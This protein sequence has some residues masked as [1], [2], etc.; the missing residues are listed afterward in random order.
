MID[1]TSPYR[2]MEL[3][4]LRVLADKLPTILAYCDRSGHCRF[5]NRAHEQW[6]GIAPETLIGKHAREIL[7]PFYARTKPHIDA[8]LAGEEREFELEMP[9]PMGGPPRYAQVQYI[10]HVV[11]GTVQGLCI[12]GVDVSRRKRAEEGL[13]ELGRQLRATERLAAM[14]TLAAGLG[15]EI[16][17]PLASVLANI[18]LA[19]EGLQGRSDAVPPVEKELLEARS[20]VQRIGSIVQNMRL[21]A[22]GDLEKWELVDVNTVVEQSVAVAAHALRYRARLLRDLGEVGQIEGNASQLAQVCVNLLLNAAQALPEETPDRNE[23]RLTTR[24]E[25]DT[26]LI[27]VADNGC[28]IPE[29]ILARI[30]EPFFT[31]KDVVGGMGLGL[32][33][34]NRTVTAL[35]GKLSV[36]SQ[37]GSGSS[38]R[39]V[40]PAARGSLVQASGVPKP[41]PPGA[42][43]AASPVVRGSE[44]LRI[45]IIDD[46]ASLGQALRRM[47]ARDHE[48]EVVIEPREAVAM[49][50]GGVLSA[51]QPDFDIIVC[52]LMMPGLSGEEV[53]TEV[54][55]QRPELAERF[56]FMT[57]GAFTARGSRF[58]DEIAAPVL[59][60]PFDA[61][62]VRTLVRE[63]AA[64]LRKANR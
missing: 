26:I 18:E 40:L 14:A 31:T 41:E 6:F 16:N 34:S 53:Y 56:I 58:L 17:N 60:K 55:K 64:G 45:L 47:L 44:S 54:I 9:D 10:P 4:L 38:F 35:G 5:A 20:G 36:A 1:P 21:L 22:R 3:A 43:H 28:G 13:H 15:H 30:F 32:S 51:G 25:N 12:L 52:D 23:I 8:A 61:T 49:L 63:H 7:G 42:V 2:D 62:R 57:G 48:V 46:Q 59:H 24:R 11:D 39:V 19:L 29:D 37:V 50:T 33:I 27:E